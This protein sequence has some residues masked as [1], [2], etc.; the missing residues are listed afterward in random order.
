MKFLLLKTQGRRQRNEQAT[1]LKYSREELLELQRD[2]QC[3]YGRLTD[4]EI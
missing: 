4:R 1:V 3:E 2:F